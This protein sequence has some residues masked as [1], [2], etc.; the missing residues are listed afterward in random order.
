MLAVTLASHTGTV[1]QI[2]LSANAPEQHCGYLG[3]EPEY[4][5]LSLYVSDIL[6]MKMYVL[7]KESGGWKLIFNL[8]NGNHIWGQFYVPDAPLP[9]QF[10]VKCSWKAEDGP[11][12]WASAPMWQTWKQL[13]FPGFGSVQLQLLW[14]LG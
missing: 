8:R 4:G 7:K 12:P 2:Q 13:L 1:V 6:L 9:I 3:S 14:L 11:M 10:L 5:I